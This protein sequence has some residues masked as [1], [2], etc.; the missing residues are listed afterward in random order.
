MDSHTQRL[1][2]EARSLGA[3]LGVHWTQIN[4]EKVQG[5]LEVEREHSAGDPGPDMN[6]DVLALT[7]G[8]TWAYLKEI[9]DRYARLDQLEPES[10]PH[11]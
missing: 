7:G 10:Q 6:G 1:I 8:R 2:E 9:W 5:G 11:D 4:L 3:Q